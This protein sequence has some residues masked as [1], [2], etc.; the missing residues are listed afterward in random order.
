M[1]KY[2]PN[3]SD[4]RFR[5]GDRAEVG[6]GPRGGDRLVEIASEARE[7]GQDGYLVRPLSGQPDE[8]L[9]PWVQPG[10]ML[11]PWTPAQWRFNGFGYSKAHPARHTHVRE[12]QTL[13]HVHLNGDL[14]HGYFGHPQDVP[15]EQAAGER[16]LC[17]GRDETFAAPLGWVVL[18][19]N[20]PVR[21]CTHLAGHVRDCTEVAAYARA[22]RTGRGRY[23]EF[24]CQAHLAE[25]GHPARSAS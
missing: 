25:M 3:K 16:W 22:A 18:P 21:P 5:L 17:A 19:G 24:A 23:D 10:R 12:G 13:E 15:A 9:L 8:G 14:P 20:G 11:V 4:H 2:Q 1:R 7:Y 6:A